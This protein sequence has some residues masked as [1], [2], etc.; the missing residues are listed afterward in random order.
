MRFY[1]A[2]AARLLSRLRIMFILGLSLGTFY[3][4]TARDEYSTWSHTTTINLNT[5][6][7]QLAANVYN[8]PL[9][10]RLN[11]TIFPF[12]QAQSNGTDIRFAK[13]D[14]TH[15]LYERER[16]NISDS[17]AE[18]WVLLDTVFMG[19]NQELR[20][21]WGNPGAAD[22]SQPERVF[23]THNGFAGLW[24]LNTQFSDATANNND[25]VNT[26]TQDNAAVV[27]RGRYFNDHNTYIEIPY[28]STLS[29][30]T[31][32]MSYWAKK[33]GIGGLGATDVVLSNHGFNQ[34]YYSG[35]GSMFNSDWTTLVAKNSDGYLVMEN[36]A[37]ILDEW[38]YIVATYDGTK[39]KMFANG[40]RT[41]T[42]SYNQTY[43]ANSTYDLFIGTSALY[44]NNYFQGIIDEVRISSRV[45][46]VDWIELSY[47]TQRPG[48]SIVTVNPASSLDIITHPQSDTVIIGSS[49]SFSIQAIGSP[50]PSGYWQKYINSVW[51]DLG[52]TGFSYQIAAATLTDTGGYRAIVTNGSISDTSQS[53]TL[54]VFDS[55]K[56]TSQ[57]QN[58]TVLVGSNASFSVSVEG[59]NLTYQW[60][61]NDN[62]WHNITV[63]G[64]SPTYSFTP[65]MNDDSIF[66]R[67]LI[68]SASKSVNS[69]SVLLILVS[70][71]VIT[72]T[73]ANDT[74]LPLG[75]YLHLTGSANSKPDP[76]YEWFFISSLSSTPVSQG[77]GSVLYINNAT[78]A[79]SGIYY[80]MASNQYGN[81][82][83]D[84]IA[85][86]IQSPVTIIAD[87]PPR[88]N[89]NNGGT[90]LLQPKVIGDGLFSYQWYSNGNPIN[91]QT[92]DSLLINPV[93]SL[94]HDQTNY[95][96]R[97]ENTYLGIAIGVDTSTICT[98]NVSPYFN[99]FKVAVERISPKNTAE[100]T[101][102][103]WSEASLVSFPSIDPGFPPSSWA[104]S[105]WIFYQSNGY[106]Q[107]VSEASV[108]RYA[109]EEI[110]QNAPTPVE[111]T[112][113][114]PKLTT[115]HDSCLWFN[116]SINWHTPDTLLR[117]FLQAD[118]VF[119]IDTVSS[120]NP[121]VVYGQ[122]LMKT[123]TVIITIS[124]LSQLDT[125]RDRDVVI[126][127]SYYSNM[128]PPVTLDTLG[129]KDLMVGGTQSSFIVD[130]IGILPL[131][132]DTMYCQWFIIGTN[133]TL[134][135]KRDTS[136]IIGWDRPLYTGELQADSTYMGDRVH[137]AWTAPPN[138][139]DS[140]RIWWD[141]SPI[142]LT[143]T[144]TLPIN[145]VHY[146][147]S[148][149]LLTDTIKNVL[150]NN[151]VYYMG[152]Q[153]CKDDLWSRITEPAIDT[154]KTALGNSNTI[155]NNIAIDSAR[156]NS[157]NNSVH[158]YWHIDLSVIPDQ[159]YL[160]FGYTYQPGSSLNS[161]YKPSQ[162]D[163]V[164]KEYNET[165]IYISDIVFDTTYAFGMWL[166]A[167]HQALGP[168]VPALP[169]DSSIVTLKTPSFTWEVVSF[170]PDSPIVFAANQQIILK[171]QLHFVHTDTLYAYDPGSLPAGFV[172]VGGI[173]FS[174]TNKT[175]GIAPFTLGLSYEQLP[176][177]I[178]P[179]HLAMYQIVNNQFQVLH[180]S[181]VKDSAVWATITNQDMTYPFVILA[182]TMKP[183]IT[184][185][186]YQDTISK[187]Y[188][189]PLIF[190]INDN[191]RNVYWRFQYGNGNNGYTHHRDNYLQQSHDTSSISVAMDPRVIHEY[192]GL[193][194]LVI[195]S[196][197]VNSDTVNVSRCV[198]N[199]SGEVF[200]I[201]QYAW[202]P[203]RTTKGLIIPLLETIFSQI[204][205]EPQE[206]S[207]NT[208]EF[209][210]FR[211]H[212]TD[213]RE[214]NNWLEYS[215]MV[216]N[217]FQLI[218][219]RI[220][221]CKSAKDHALKLGAG[222]TT[223]LKEPYTIVLRPG[224]WTDF[225]LPFQFSITLRD[226]LAATGSLRDS[227]DMYQWIKDQNTYIAKDIYLSEFDTL[228]E[229]YDTL[230][231]LQG[232]DA[233]TVYNHATQPVNLRIPPIS[234]AISSYLNPPIK[235]RKEKNPHLWHISFNWDD[236]QVKGET[237]YKRV[238]CGYKQGDH[239]PDYGI[240]PPT[241]S[242]LQVGVLNRLKNEICGWALVHDIDQNGGV[243][244]EI[245]LTNNY[246]ETKNINY[247]LAN[248]ATLPDD[249]LA[250][251]YNP[252]TKSY[253][254]STS[255][256]ISQLTLEPGSRT[257]RIIALGPENYFHT[258]FQPVK[259]LKAF[260][261][262]FN[263]VLILQYQLP[264]NIKEVRLALYNIQGKLLWHQ[265]NHNRTQTGI[266]QLYF[267]TDMINPNQDLATGVYFIHLSAIDNSGTKIFGG[268]KRIFL[269]K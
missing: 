102:K 136:F 103:I 43:R 236:A 195:A 84:S 152:L 15:L 242:K 247:Y 193:R 65:D 175:P 241:M 79:D 85:I 63:N 64:S 221:W 81:I 41:P 164:S 145:Q 143:H 235:S 185:S 123:D 154:V 21:F 179:K 268:K 100:V 31:F 243:S 160:Q 91:N 17:V 11:Q 28:S 168:T 99:P 244:F 248:L 50:S 181:E 261:N 83:S 93:D 219:G 7:L 197:G 52:A 27:G 126:L 246:T 149:L 69:D 57:P 58:D 135:E 113:R 224:N 265:I 2:D 184:V 24:H 178:L 55:L 169:T 74:A 203:L 213:S 161:A 170:F 68:S 70:E 117:P 257:T 33:T 210:L 124:N 148:P 142:K 202:V 165:E 77:N 217:D 39:S 262:P 207:Y 157:Q 116:Y 264:Q 131:E 90:V 118:K 60:Q 269:V 263:R 260:P 6:S 106:A 115:P 78:K 40:S 158:I 250:R 159:S 127:I 30:S 16:W 174:F 130:R 227:L 53:A 259:L 22:S 94:V 62:G 139:T 238:L 254:V 237:F 212:T 133:M 98:L 128:N 121:L 120:S 18:F 48:Q 109:T 192:F 209:R 151:T 204:V 92:G 82:S 180:D 5:S 206:W 211:W 107:T 201:N 223:S 45:R 37:C 32:T 38:V 12:S 252:E 9:L 137:L 44:P 119:V 255:D 47:A 267:A 191:C 61:R 54:T 183:T 222:V 56:I 208:E 59:F 228:T 182:D 101:I 42:D 155:A 199:P 132:K 29:T 226:V 266:H 71:P 162:W 230:K 26:N 87:I 176:S 245:V 190:T 129:I 8:F 156:F 112:L 10:I 146:V 73:F 105:I 186:A 198:R 95:F 253:T 34:G 86:H 240:L 249:F 23:D 111:Y 200:S 215:H 220:I 163:S 251:V 234:L 231:S 232:H 256:N 173:S 67:C 75:G 89:I 4:I 172:S 214:P 46:S 258:L 122:Y 166:R 141:Q 51:T 153:I 14:G 205:N 20:M 108:V 167:F 76:S 35:A 233:F 66:V 225:S 187:N 216:K 229:I 25:G 218:P 49:A 96:L 19:R 13:M 80:F 138:G 147:V 125:L 110:K 189:D 1:L 72:S 114:I 171:E 97:V 140:I 194:A 177:G 239:D 134:S 36:F 150:T 144:P 196:D 88:Y 188:T 3:S 104:D